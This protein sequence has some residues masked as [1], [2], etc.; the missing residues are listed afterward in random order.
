MVAGLL[1]SEFADRGQHTERVASQH[2][3]VARLTVDNARNLGVRDELNRVS[4]TSVLGNADIVVIGRA[5]CGAVD[6]VLEDG[7]EPD[8]VEDLGLFFCGKVDALGV[9]PSFDVEDTGVGPYM[10]VVTDEE[11]VGV[12]G[13][14]CL[15]SSRETEEESDVT[16]LHAHVGRGVKRKLA[17][18]DRLEVMLQT[19]SGDSFR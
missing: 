9:T 13:E 15:S 12:S 5:I 7:A 17:K 3:D 11:T 18:L 14:G 6:D 19:K 16:L 8:S 4:A 2:N 1:G 10:F